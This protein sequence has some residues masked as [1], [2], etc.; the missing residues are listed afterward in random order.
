MGRRPAD[1]QAM[2][3]T[4]TFD[5][6]HLLAGHAR[7]LPAP[8]LPGPRGPARSIATKGSLDIRVV[9]EHA[10]VEERLDKGLGESHVG[11]ATLDPTISTRPPSTGRS[12]PRRRAW[13]FRSDRTATCA[14]NWTPQ[15][16]SPAVTSDTVTAGPRNSARTS[17]PGHL[18]KAISH[19]SFAGM[20]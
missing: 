12:I 20:R 3:S 13:R 19:V 14:A 1:Q 2:G 7:D 6:R 9:V 16:A 17:P 10:V 15:W 5:D 4:D 11:T 8:T 18:E